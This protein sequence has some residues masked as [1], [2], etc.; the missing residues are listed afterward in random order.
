[1]FQAFNFCFCCFVSKTEVRKI[2]HAI[3]KLIAKMQK[4][5]FE[6]T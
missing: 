5:I 2:D 3:Y 6:I 4:S 1:M